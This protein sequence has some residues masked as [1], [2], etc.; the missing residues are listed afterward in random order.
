MP[1]ALPLVK[2]RIPKKP[3]VTA[4]AA[5]TSPAESFAHSGK[6]AFAAAAAVTTP[7]AGADSPAAAAVWAGAAGEG[8]VGAAA[9]LRAEAA[10][11]TAPL[12][13]AAG[14]GVP[15]KTWETLP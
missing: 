8:C 1:E 3:P 2:A 9:A 7:T 10:A 6:P 12:T 4:I 5:A 14:R 13:A 15:N 11:W